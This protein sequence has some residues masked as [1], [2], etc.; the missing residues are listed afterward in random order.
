MTPLTEDLRQ[1]IERANGT[2]ARLIDPDTSTEYVVIRADVY[3]RL[4]PFLEDEPLTEAEELGLLREMGRTAGWD[5]PEMDVYND[6][7]P[8]H[9]A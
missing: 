4:K 9:K 5:E 3:E 7:D 6:L 2:P 8:R 1:E